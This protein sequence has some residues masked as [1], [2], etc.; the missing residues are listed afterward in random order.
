M[1][2]EGQIIEEVGRENKYQ[3]CGTA[4]LGNVVDGTERGYLVSTSYT[5]DAD[6]AP[7]LCRGIFSIR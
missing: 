2:P 7:T 5:R 3:L 1:A 4:P 6:D